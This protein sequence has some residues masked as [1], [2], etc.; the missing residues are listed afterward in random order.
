MTTL[1]DEAFA[2]QALVRALREAMEDFADDDAE[3]VAESETRL[4]ETIEAALAAN[5]EDAAHVDAIKRV[6]ADLEAR[7]ARKTARIE[8]R[9]GA[10]LAAMEIAGVAKLEL[11]TATVSVS[12]GKPKVIITDGSAIEQKYFVPSV[13][14]ALSRE[15]IRDDLLA[16]K[17]VI[18]A[19]M[20]NAAP[21]LIVRTK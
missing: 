12:K 2:A 7:A 4:P 6:V 19:I 17:E 3:S 16:G 8:R 21:T 1:R 14:V 18:G 5:A 11:A 13:K 20:S 9:R 10:I 15:L